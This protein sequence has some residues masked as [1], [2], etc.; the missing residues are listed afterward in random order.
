MTLHRK[1][2]P[3]VTS[4]RAAR[5]APR[6]AAAGAMWRT[7]WS[8]V[9]PSGRAPPCWSCT[10]WRCCRPAGQLQR[11]QRQVSR[12]SARPPGAGD[13][14]CR[15]AGVKAGGRVPPGAGPPARDRIA[16]A[17]PP[18]HGPDKAPRAPAG[19][20]LPPSPLVFREHFLPREDASGRSL[21]STLITA[22]V[23]GSSKLVS[24]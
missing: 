2:V 18:R 23:G 13:T 21:V 22:G 5:A 6:G 24:G 7:A 15:G 16:A 9:W 11:K 19:R 4:R 10:V 17:P 3:K 1:T 20:H 12:A 8:T 14:G